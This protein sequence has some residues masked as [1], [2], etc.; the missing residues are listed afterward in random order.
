MELGQKEE[1]GHLPSH[2]LVFLLSFLITGKLTT[3]KKNRQN[4]QEKIGI[5]KMTIKRTHLLFILIVQT[6][7]STTSLV[8]KFEGK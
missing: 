1:D 2:P 6:I 7:K 4:N 5:P 8:G 3:H